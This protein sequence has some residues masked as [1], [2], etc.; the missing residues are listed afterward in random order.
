[1][2]GTRRLLTQNGCNPNWARKN[3]GGFAENNLD[4]FD[5]TPVLFT[6][7]QCVDELSVSKCMREQRVIVDIRDIP[8][9]YLQISSVSM[10]VP[11]IV[12]TATE[13]VENRKNGWVVQSI[14]EIADAL[15]HYLDGVANWNEA[16]VNAYEIGKKYT[17]DR[18]LV[19]WREVIKQIG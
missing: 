8:E 1:M 16:V 18:L 2:S 6:V 3:Q 11:Q 14:D 13:F 15:Q 10:G 5:E 12:R 17:T 9:L 4:E 7:E 19:Q